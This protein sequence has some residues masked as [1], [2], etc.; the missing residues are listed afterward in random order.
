MKDKRGFIWFGTE[1]GLNRFD[2]KEVTIF[3]SNKKR[4][5]GVLVNTITCMIEDKA[6]DLIYIGTNGGGVS[7]YDPITEKFKHYVYDASDDCLSSSFVYDLFLRNDG[8]V[9]VANSYGVSILNPDDGTFDNFES[10]EEPKGEFPFVVATS[11]YSDEEG[12]IWAGTYGLGIVRM[13]TASR[14][15]RRY[16]DQYGKQQRYNSN[17]IDEIV[18]S[19][20]SRYLWVATDNGFYEFDKNTGVYKLL[21]LE[22]TK[23]SDVAVDEHNGIWLSSGIA[24]LA[25]VTP[26]GELIRYQNDPYD[27]HSLEDNAIR[28]LYLDDR[29]HLWIGTKSRGCIH[30]DVSAN[31]FV[32]Y[33]Q[34]KDGKGVNGSSIYAL[35]KDQDENVWI[36]TMKGLS[37]WNSDKGS[38]TPYYPL[39]HKE[40]ISTWAFYNDSKELLWIGTSQGLFKH[41]KVTKATKVFKYIDGDTTSLSD[42]E[43]FALEKDA[44]G[45][46]WVGTAYGLSKFDEKNER[47]KRYQFTNFDSTYTNEVI[48]D[49][50]C[51]SKKRLW[52]TSQYGVNMYQPETDT[53]I[54]L[55][56]NK[57]DSLSLASYNVMSVYE[58]SQNRIWLSTA[59]GINQVNDELKIVKFYG[60]EHGM[61][62]AYAY[63]I[64]EYKNEL[65]VSTNKGICRI[66]LATDEIISYDVQD[67]LQSNE[68]NPASE[69]LADGRLLFGGIN[70]FNVF[71]PDSIKQSNYSPAIYFTSLELHGQLDEESDTLNIEQSVIK[72][73]LITTAR[74]VFKPN[75]RFFTINFAALDYKEPSGIHYFYRMLPKSSDWIPL[76]DKPNLTFIDLSPGTYMLEVRSTNA[77]GFVCDNTKSI[78]IIVKPPLWKEAWFI[79]LL[80]VIAIVWVYVAGRLY[81]MRLKRDKQILERRVL[82]RTREI[83]LQRNI[84]NRKR[85]EIARQK[86][87]IESFARNLEALVEKRTVELKTAKEAAEE[88]DRL[89][90]AFLSNMSHEIR[91]PMNAIMGFSELLLDSSFS[92]DEKND[93]AHLIRTNGDNLLN[94]LN[95]I[96]DISMI[97]S[98]QLNVV[99]NPVDVT[100]LVKEVYETFKTA[101]VLQTKPAI[102]YELLCTEDPIIIS[103]DAFRLRQILNNLI[104]NALKFTNSGYV[105]LVLKKQDNRAFFSVEDSGIGISLEHQSRIFERFSRIDNTSENLYAGNGLGLTITRNLVELLDGAIYV[106]S[107]LGVGTSFYF[108]LPLINET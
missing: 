70:G 92:A 102:K 37:V 56:N 104:S 90:S 96:I 3:N 17:I 11:I 24:G 39:N 31:Q 65:W 105:K 74:L 57:S 95:D 61:P 30:M 100:A 33:Y 26:G 55:F 103:T 6:N 91:T 84:A 98:G 47:F 68:F 73:S 78:Q 46:L 8:K 14:S 94:L 9:V 32:H 38:V 27:I 45:N 77:E 81:Y 86:E 71:H 19:P 107:E 108:Y 4:D 69:E 1:D 21:Y 66:N 10:S 29:K 63:Q 40:D 2:G 79:S 15:Y 75:Q 53:F 42:N 18:P 101:K 88:S 41:N 59:N 99:L 16:V 62:N 87:E 89:K 36:G 51:D 106:E 72:S 13:D 50:F 44:E 76:K 60:E 49:V 48:W 23:V 97:E 85:D 43:V 67:G 28:C 52:I 22:N 35:N 58:D 20:D 82:T 5:E 93:F 12:I 25:Y 64:R 7:V 34:T 80:I 83:Q 54:Y